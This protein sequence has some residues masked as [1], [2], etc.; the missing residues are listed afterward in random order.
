MRSAESGSSHLWLGFPLAFLLA[1][2]AGAAQELAEIV[3]AIRSG[4][5]P[6]S[7]TNMG[8]LTSPVHVLDL[9]LLLPT[10]VMTGVMLL[11]RRAVVFVLAP[12]LMVFFVLMSLALAG[13]VLA[14]LPDAIPSGAGT[15]ALQIRHLQA[16]AVFFFIIPSAP[17]S[18]RCLSSHFLDGEVSE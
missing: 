5:A 7:V 8:L 4:Q 2:T 18:S 11:R 15:P 13:M 6:Q 10:L 9:S 1:V 3:A 14:L 17:P 12:I 16:A